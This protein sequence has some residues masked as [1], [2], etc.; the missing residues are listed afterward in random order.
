MTAARHCVFA[1]LWLSV[2]GISVH[3]G[4]LVLA[5]RTIIPVTELNPIGRLLMHVNG[6]DIW[7][8]L[9]IK[10]LGTVCAAALLLVLYWTGSPFAWGACIATAGVQVLLLIFL[11]QG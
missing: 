8:L 3:D 6:G 5:H 9:A 7:I 11:Y 2:I 10:A 4:Y 1:L